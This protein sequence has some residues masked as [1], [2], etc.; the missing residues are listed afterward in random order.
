M[1][2]LEPAPHFKSKGNM[3][4]MQAIQICRMWAQAIAVWEYVY[5]AWEV[6]EVDARFR[7]TPSVNPDFRRDN[8]QQI[9]ASDPCAGHVMSWNHSGFHP[10]RRCRSARADYPVPLRPAVL[11]SMLSRGFR[12]QVQEIIRQ[13]TPCQGARPAAIVDNSAPPVRGKAHSWHHVQAGV[14]PGCFKV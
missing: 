4:K 14:Y 5:G 7:F 1:A 13:S 8:F 10:R 12:V 2:G 9:A 3:D 11:N 6:L